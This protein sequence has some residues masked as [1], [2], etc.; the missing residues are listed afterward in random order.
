MSNSKKRKPISGWIAIPCIFIVAAL[1]VYAL[2]YFLKPDGSKLI[3]NESKEESTAEN[4]G[5]PSAASSS[6]GAESSSAESSASEESE[7]EEEPQAQPEAQVFT[8]L[9]QNYVLFEED[10][11][12]VS[13]ANATS[14]LVQPD[15]ALSNAPEMAFDGDPVTSWQEGVE[16]NGEGEVITAYFDQET[17][18]TA[19]V[20][21][22]GNWRN[23]RA[24]RRNNTPMEMEIT[25]GGFTYNFTFEELMQ[26]QYV[27]FSEPVQHVTEVVMKIN[28]IY[29]GVT[30]DTCISEITFYKGA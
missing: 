26:E 28:S 17:T 21:Y 3:Y 18:V 9:P 29:E 13:K 10:L 12:A 7:P 6:S 19:M 25:L 1:L 27:I 14:E 8:E 22:L 16:G 23:E 24:Y 11:L 30:G 15:I 20:F 4:E 5:S 2:F